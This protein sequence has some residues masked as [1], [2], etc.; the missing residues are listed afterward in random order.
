MANTTVILGH[1]NNGS[2]AIRISISPELLLDMQGRTFEIVNVKVP[3]GVKSLSESS[4]P[5]GQWIELPSNP[6]DPYAATLEIRE[7]KE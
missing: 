7:I 3:Y 6:N 4:R 1:Y 5:E 2:G